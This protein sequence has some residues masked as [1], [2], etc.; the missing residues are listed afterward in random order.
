MGLGYETGR[1]VDGKNFGCGI[2]IHGLPV[3]PEGYSVALYFNADGE[4]VQRINGFEVRLHPWVGVQL[5]AFGEG[6]DWKRRNIEEYEP[7]EV[8]RYLRSNPNPGAP[9]GS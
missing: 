6:R 3:S 2:P 8:M 1:R 7:V 5:E 9:A 4:F